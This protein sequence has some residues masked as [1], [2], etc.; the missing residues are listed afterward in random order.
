MKL[1]IA[2]AQ[3]SPDYQSRLIK[4]LED[5]LRNKRG[6]GDVELQRQA[7]GGVARDEHLILRSP[8]GTRYALTVDNAGSI[9]VDLADTT[10]SALVWEDQIGEI[11]VRGSGANNPTWAVYRGNIRQYQFSNVIMNEV[12]ANFHITHRWAR[13]D[14]YLHAHWSQNVADAGVAAK[15]SFEV[16]YA[17]GHNTAAFVAPIST[18]VTQ[19]SSSTQYQH[20]IAEVQLTADSPSAS[21][22]D[23]QDLDV[24]ALLL[25]RVFRD[26]TD[27]ADT[28]TQA[29][30]LHYVD[31]HF[32]CDRQGTKNKAPDFDA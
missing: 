24:D 20:L 17:K 7:V 25:V 2:P 4:V 15:W 6:I 28:L 5:E 3:W 1:P 16:T 27:P 30:F 22:I 10:T 23:N 31:L 29:P 9:W 14:I 11:E 26:P 19:N 8:N 18:S 13:N 21:Q 12:W 32:Q